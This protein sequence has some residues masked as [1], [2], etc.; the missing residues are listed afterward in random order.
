MI[1]RYLTNGVFE[2]LQDKMVFIGGPRQVGKTTLARYI[3]DSFYSE[4]T[5]YLNWDNRDDRRS[6]LDGRF[7]GENKLVIKDNKAA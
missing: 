7:R 5:E 4:K 3:G 2:D 1:K 6:I